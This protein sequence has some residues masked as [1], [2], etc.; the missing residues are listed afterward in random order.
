MVQ[1]ICNKINID[2]QFKLD[3][4]DQLQRSVVTVENSFP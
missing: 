1:I 2:H 4:S 3:D